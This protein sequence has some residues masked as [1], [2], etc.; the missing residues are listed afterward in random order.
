MLYH[1]V[2]AVPFSQR[3]LPDEAPLLSDS[4][5]FL[6]AVQYEEDSTPC[7]DS[8]IQMK[9]D[10]DNLQ[11]QYVVYKYSLNGTFLGSEDVSCALL[12]MLRK[13]SVAG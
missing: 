11:L 2:F 10:F 7:L 13:N 3:L 1:R 12:L 8:S 9:M 5:I 4:K 6:Y